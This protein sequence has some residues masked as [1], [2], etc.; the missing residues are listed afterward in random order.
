MR[1]NRSFPRGARGFSLVELMVAMVAGLIVLGAA[2]VFTVTSMRSYSENILSSKLTQEL[3]TSMNLVVRELRRAGHDSTSVTRVLTTTS[4]S[5]FDDLAVDGDCITYEYDRQVGA[6]GPDATEIRG[7]RLNEDTGT[8][9][10]NAS[11]AAIDCDNDADWEDITDP[12]VVTIT[13]FEPVMVESTFCSQIAERDLD[14]DDVIDE[15]DMA[16]GSVR[17]VSLCLAGEMV[18]GDAITRYVTDSVRI[19]AED[20]RFDFATDDNTCEP[21]AD[22]PANPE[23]LYDGCDE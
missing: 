21:T 20:L 6:D 18:S 2:V 7:F 22:A 12:E 8:L 15:Y 1:L 17:T 23:D 11:G 10:L 5:T 16:H 13:K 9:Q 4:A 14:G 19:R 3:R